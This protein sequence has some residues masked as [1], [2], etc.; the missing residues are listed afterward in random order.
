MIGEGHEGEETSLLLGLLHRRLEELG[1]WR[2][3]RAVR[4]V[5]RRAEFLTDNGE[6]LVGEL[7]ATARFCLDTGAGG[8]LHP[9][10]WSLREIAMVDSVHLS[11][12][13]QGVVT[14]H[15]D[16]VSPVTGRGPGGRCQ[17]GL[18]QITAHVRREVLPLALDRARSGA[19][20][21]P[22]LVPR[23][24]AIA[25]GGLGLT[26]ASSL[27]QSPDLGGQVDRGDI[28]IVAAAGEHGRR[29]GGAA[30]GVSGLVSLILSAGIGVLLTGRLVHGKRSLAEAGHT[31]FDLPG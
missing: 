22:V 8:I 17:Y 29:G 14:A 30:Q 1:V 11:V 4:M 21:G 23:I 10:Q 15:I 13:R 6:A 2:H 25:P 9:G 20:R 24:P 28:T 26:A 7:L 5:A 3:M 12:D 31:T 18:A 19:R 16:G 27:H